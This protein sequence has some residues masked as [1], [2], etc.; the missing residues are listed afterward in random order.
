MNKLLFRQISILS[1][2]FGAILGVLSLIPVIRNVSVIGVTIFLA[3][4]VII[5][6]KKLNLLQDIN[7]KTGMVMGTISGI[8]SVTAFV[9]AFTPVDLL[10]GLFIK[11]GYIEWISI[12]IKNAGFFNYILIL[13]FLCILNG[14]TNAFSGLATAYLYD[15]LKGMKDNGRI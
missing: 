1:G 14:T 10:L 2:I 11:N 4:A 6:L 12:L 5:Y 15:M 3:P 8:I 13:F 9:I 7:I